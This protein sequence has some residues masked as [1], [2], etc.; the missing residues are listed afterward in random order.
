MRSGSLL[1]HLQDDICT[2]LQMI[3][4]LTIDIA[5]LSSKG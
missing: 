1:W 4:W 5:I 3:H 2:L